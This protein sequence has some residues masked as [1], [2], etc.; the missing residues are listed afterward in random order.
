MKPLIIWNYSA[1]SQ[2]I[3]QK[4]SNLLKCKLCIVQNC[5]RA[6]NTRYVK[7]MTPIEFVQTK[8][9]RW[10]L[11]V[12]KFCSSNACRSEVGRFPMRTKTKCR[13]IKYWLKFCEP[14]HQNKL[15][16][17]AFTDQIGQDKKE[18]WPSKLKRLL[19]LAG[20]GDIWSAKT[21]TP[22][23]MSYIRQRLLDIEQQTWTSEIH[24]DEPA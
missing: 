3:W 10:L 16:G 11:G 18:L 1:L 19:N 22:A 4:Q 21:N 24:N 6:Q 12:N 23:I 2:F 14:E 7:L 15:S 17:I 8:F 9:I 13:A 5:F 20:L